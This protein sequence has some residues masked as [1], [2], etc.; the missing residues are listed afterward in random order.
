MTP[1]FST[2]LNFGMFSLLQRLHRI[3]IQYCLENDSETSEIIKYPRK[4]IHKNKDGHDRACVYD[5]SNISNS[6][7]IETVN[8]AKEEAKRTIESL[9]M[10]MIY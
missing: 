4:E 3:H 7:I 10:Y 5:L 1:T 2:V 6:K 8:K 9:G